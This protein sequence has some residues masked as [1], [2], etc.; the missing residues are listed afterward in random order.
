MPT[1][2]KNCIST[3]TGDT[4]IQKGLLAEKNNNYRS[5][6]SILLL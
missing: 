4:L 5:P 2:S 6:S 1:A 3:E